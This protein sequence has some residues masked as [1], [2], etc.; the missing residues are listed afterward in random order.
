MKKLLI[1][2]GLGI[3]AVSSFQEVAADFRPQPL[4]AGMSSGEVLTMWGS[5]LERIERE[6]KREETWWYP[7]QAMVAFASGKVVDWRLG[8]PPRSAIPL[9]AAMVAA[10]DSGEGAEKKVENPPVSD[11]DMK[12]ILDE[13]VERGESAPEGSS[14]NPRP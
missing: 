10:L 6:A 7:G 3:I 9:S 14:P 8:T 4:T 11:G 5:P 12:E 2:L 13:I 1:R